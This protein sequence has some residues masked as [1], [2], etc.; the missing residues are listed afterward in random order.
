MNY[1]LQNAQLVNDVVDW[2]EFG[3]TFGIPLLILAALA[4]FARRDVWP[5]ITKQLE[6]TAADRRAELDKF[7]AAL[8]KRDQLLKEHTAQIS[9]VMANQA[10][11]LAELTEAINRIRQAIE[12]DRRNQ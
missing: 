1:V 4:Y 9:G 10:V 11:R 12:K 7:L 5:L 3:K 8:D 2:V 6:Q